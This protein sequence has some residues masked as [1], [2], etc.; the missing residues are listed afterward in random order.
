MEHVHKQQA[1]ANFADNAIQDTDDEAEL[2]KT[3]AHDHCLES[4]DD[5]RDNEMQ[6]EN[7]EE[8]YAQFNNSRIA[9]EQTEY[10]PR[11]ENTNQAGHSGAGE[12]GAKGAQRHLS[13]PFRLFCTQVLA[14]H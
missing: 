6:D 4:T 8:C 14:D 3:A 12:C 13:R 1:Q 5:G 7:V 11:Q 9:G 2:H 10:L